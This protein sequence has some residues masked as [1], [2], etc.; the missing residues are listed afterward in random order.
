MTGESFTKCPRAIAGFL[1]FPLLTLLAKRLNYLLR[2]ASRKAVQQHLAATLAYRKALFSSIM[3]RAF[4]D[5]A[6]LAPIDPTKFLSI[7]QN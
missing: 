5:Q 2:R 1:F 7:F 3:C 4:S 6:M